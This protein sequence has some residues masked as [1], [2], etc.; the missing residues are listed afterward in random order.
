MK[1]DSEDIFS[2]DA[3][4]LASRNV[5]IECIKRQ[6]FFATN[7]NYEPEFEEEVEEEKSI[8]SF[9]IM[10]I[11]AVLLV[12]NPS[13]V[14]SAVHGIFKLQTTMNRAVDYLYQEGLR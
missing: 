8:R 4:A 10:V 3:A 13:W 14:T 12:V 6:P 7:S 9:F 1:N 2:E 11:V 5:A